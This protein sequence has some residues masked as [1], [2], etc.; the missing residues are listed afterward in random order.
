MSAPYK[1]TNPIWLSRQDENNP[2]LNPHYKR[3][4]RYYNKLY[5]AWPTWCSEHSGYKRIY[6]EAKRRRNNGDNVHVDHIVPICSHIVCGL[7]VP[8]N[9]Q[10]IPEKENLTKS[11]TWWPDHPFENEDMFDAFKPYQTRILF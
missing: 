3:S 2:L 11:N 1:K 4:I 8:W 7:H 6:M 10:I 9:L 5:L